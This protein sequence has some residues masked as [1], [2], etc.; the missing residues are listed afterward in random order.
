MLG[1]Y[2]KIL[3]MARGDLPQALLISEERGETGR[4]QSVLKA[5]VA[6]GTT[7]DL[8]WAK[9]LAD[10]QI[11]VGAFVSLLRNSSVFYKALDTGMVRLPFN[12]QVALV[13]AGAT[14]GIVG[15]GNPA[16]VTRLSLS[17]VSL[18][19][20]LATSMIVLS[21]ELV[22]STSTA[23]EVLMSRELRRG[24]TAAVDTEFLSLITDASTSTAVSTGIARADLRALLDAVK[25]KAESRLMW[26][27]APDVARAAATLSLADGTDVFP[28]MG[29][30]GGEMLMIPAIVS[31]QMATGTIGLLD[32][33]GIAGESDTIT[34]D[35]SNQA[36]LEMNDAPGGGAGATLVSMWQHNMVSIL[37]KAHFAAERLRSDAWATVTGVV[38]GDPVE[39]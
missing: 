22:R 35:A 31:D 23:S 27:L 19:P 24:I 10:H 14:A 17:G 30:T 25:P 2:A 8:A 9:P 28:A 39:E 13:T 37:A 26:V 6:A 16:P 12:T 36:T 15:E 5:A 34:I 4:V 33:T 38:W 32:T 11:I 7:T 21:D 18:Q 20:K 29:P 1:A 3:A